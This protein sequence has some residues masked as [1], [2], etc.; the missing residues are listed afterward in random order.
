MTFVRNLSV[1][2]KLLSARKKSE[3]RPIAPKGRLLR[4]DFLE[5]RRLLTAS[6]GVAALDATACEIPTSN[7]GSW[8]IERARSV[9]C[10]DARFF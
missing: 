3:R 7:V 9:E 5:D 1:W 10:S 2:Q 4:L 8:R 6:V